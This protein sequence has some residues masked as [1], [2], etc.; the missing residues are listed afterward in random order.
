MPGVC[1]VRLLGSLN[2]N[3]HNIFNVLKYG[4]KADGQTDDSTAFLAAWNAA[5]SST[6]SPVVYV[7]KMTILINPV[8]FQGPC[9]SNKITM[10]VAGKLIASTDNSLWSEKSINYWLQFMNVIG[11]TVEGSRILDGRGA[12]SCTE[13]NGKV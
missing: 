1:S 7:P 9:H 4:A 5:C 13:V 2:H 10:Q 8:I 3:T 6:G 11:L 12:S